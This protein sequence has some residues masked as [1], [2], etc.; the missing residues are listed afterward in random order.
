LIPNQSPLSIPSP[1]DAAS[2][3]PVTP[4]ALKLDGIG[5]DIKR[6]LEESAQTIVV[7]RKT[8]T[9]VKRCTS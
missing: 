2:G 7:L 4:L 1:I 5:E 9:E 3:T 6:V 8:I